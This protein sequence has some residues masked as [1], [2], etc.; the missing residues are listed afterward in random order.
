[1]HVS[2]RTR[3]FTQIDALLFSRWVGDC[4]LVSAMAE[5]FVKQRMNPE[6]NALEAISIPDHIDILGKLAC[7]KVQ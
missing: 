6:T 7:G 4:T 3:R 1:M 2:H 5:T